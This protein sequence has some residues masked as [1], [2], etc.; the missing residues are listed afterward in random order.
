MSLWE[1]V[2]GHINN[3]KTTDDEEG[4]DKQGK[5][6]EAGQQRGDAGVKEEHTKSEGSLGRA[7]AGSKLMSHH[8]G[9]VFLSA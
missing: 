2:S 8:L 9:C 4:K 7:W 3:Q 6:P 1:P 5:H